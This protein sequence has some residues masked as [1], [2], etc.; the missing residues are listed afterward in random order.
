MKFLTF[1]FLFLLS[2]VVTA[3]ISGPALI[4]DGDTITISG[5]KVR[6]SG[7]DTPERKQTCR[8]A[9]VIWKCGYEATETLREWTHTKEVRCIG[10]EKDRYGRLIAD[11]FVDG[12]NVNARLVYEGMALAYR[13]YSKR[14]VPEENKAKAAKRG[15]W[16]GEFVAPWDWR[17]GRRLDQEE[18]PIACCKVCKKGKACG[19]SCIKKT[20][21]CSK[22]KGC[23]CD[24]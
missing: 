17:K 3:D 16:A 24:G 4:V 6:L 21:N 10:D 5:M 7:I 2:S 13:K 18:A 23:A 11:C 12:Y 20:Y 15:L 1:I 8:K 19:N 22:P 9:G 14:Y